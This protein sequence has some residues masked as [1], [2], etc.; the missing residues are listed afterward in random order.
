MSA[1]LCALRDHD[2]QIWGKLVSVAI[3]RN[4]TPPYVTIGFSAQPSSLLLPE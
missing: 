3:I 1:S 2:T 4:G